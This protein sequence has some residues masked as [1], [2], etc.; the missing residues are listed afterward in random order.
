MSSKLLRQ[1]TEI[2]AVISEQLEEGAD[3]LMDLLPVG[4]SMVINSAAAR[5]C[6]RKWL[7]AH[8]ISGSKKK[9][10]ACL[11]I[12]LSKAYAAYSSIELSKRDLIVSK[13][14]CS[15]EL[16]KAFAAYSSIH[17]QTTWTQ[18]CP[19]VSHPAGVCVCVCVCVG[20][21][22]CVR[23]FVRVRV[24]VRVCVCVCVCVCEYVCVCV[25]VC[26]CVS[27]C[28][29]YMYVGSTA[30][31]PAQEIAGVPPS[32]E[33]I[34][35]HLVDAAAEALCQMSLCAQAPDEVDVSI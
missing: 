26:V 2:A 10:K 29:I 15:I 13:E 17:L 28:V 7:G 16:S 35:A 12:E 30:P 20:V 5:A 34:P 14:T 24:R 21:G 27:L 33:P 9:M 32:P 23:A 11:A 1:V 4:V 3:A 31:A 25:C 19:P 18:L 6:W 22:V 8:A